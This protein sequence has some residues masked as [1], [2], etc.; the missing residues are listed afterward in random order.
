M[1]LEYRFFL[2]SLCYLSVLT[3]EVDLSGKGYV[4]YEMGVNG[5]VHESFCEIHERQ[6]EDQGVPLFN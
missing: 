4:N 3:E 6:G 2:C 1:L 5:P